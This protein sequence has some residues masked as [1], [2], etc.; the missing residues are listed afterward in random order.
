MRRAVLRRQRLDDPAVLTDQ[1]QVAGEVR[2]RAEPVPAPQPPPG[3]GDQQGQPHLQR[4]SARG[5]EGDRRARQEHHPGQQ[6]AG[7]ARRRP[8]AHHGQGPRAREDGDL[9]AAQPEYE[10]P[11]LQRA[12]LVLRQLRRPGHVTSLRRH[13]AEAA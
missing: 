13:G 12:E 1:G 6:P 2:P 8:K 4:P 7:C 10:A 9:A 11:A 3:V 5:Q